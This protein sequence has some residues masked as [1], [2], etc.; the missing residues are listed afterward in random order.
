VTIGGAPV[1][2]GDLIL[3][4]DDGLVC[5]A[6]GSVTSGLGPVREKAALEAGWEARLQAG[7]PAGKV[8]GLEPPEAP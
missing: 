4:D 6:A 5:L 7:E 1:A 8:F 3:G 2:P